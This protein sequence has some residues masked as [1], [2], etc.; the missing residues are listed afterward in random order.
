ML[1]FS[2]FKEKEKPISIFSKRC[3]DNSGIFQSQSHAITI[4]P[5]RNFEQEFADIGSKGI[6]VSGM[7]AISRTGGKTKYNTK[8]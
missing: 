7:H 2:S 1:F 5:T 8:I 4:R 6:A 3:R